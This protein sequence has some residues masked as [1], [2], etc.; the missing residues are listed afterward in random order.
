MSEYPWAKVLSFADVRRIRGIVADYV[1]HNLKVPG[2]C[3]RGNGRRWSK[4]EAVAAE[5]SIQCS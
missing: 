3:P 2:S 1:R 5:L 4:R